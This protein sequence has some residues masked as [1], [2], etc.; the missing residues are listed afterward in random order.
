MK[1]GICLIVVCILLSARVVAVDVPTEQADLFAADDLWDGMNDRTSNIMGMYEPTV[2]ADLTDGV[3]M[4]LSDALSKSGGFIR[5]TLSVMLSI[6]ASLILCRVMGTLGGERTASAAILVGALAITTCCLADI[7]SMIGLGQ[8]TIEEIN[9]F[10]TLLLPVLAAAATASGAAA[11]GGAI[12]A[13][14]ALFCDILIRVCRHLFIPLVYAFLSLGLADGALGQNRLGKLRELVGWIMKT[15][16]KTVLYVFTGFL[17]A[18]GVISGTA[19]AAALKAAKLTISGMIPIV[20]GIVSDASETLLASAGVLKSAVGT[21][22]MLTVL[23]MFMVPFLQLGISYLGF[24]LT[25]AVGGLLESGQDKLLDT[26]A[27]AMG[28]LLAMV[29]SCSAM[30]FI[31]C[32]CL[33]RVAAV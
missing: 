8:G 33:I 18:S 22:G 25:A 26:L 29:G 31:S 9:S 12:Y 6:F 21:F 20:G 30:A 3:G 23:A 10:T 4:I 15:L 2:Q 28:Y 27:G 5:T 19:D 13:V 32:C 17:T 16:L 1:R 11:S 7:R 24:K 14:A